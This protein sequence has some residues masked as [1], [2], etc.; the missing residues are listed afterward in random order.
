MNETY[1]PS[2]WQ[3]WL[4]GF[5]IDRLHDPFALQVTITNL[6][7]DDKSPA[8]PWHMTFAHAECVA[9]RM[10][11]GTCFCAEDLADEIPLDELDEAG[12]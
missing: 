2:R 7:L 10:P 9:E 8:T 3:C 11:R 6:Y 5:S 12:P 4:C 1:E